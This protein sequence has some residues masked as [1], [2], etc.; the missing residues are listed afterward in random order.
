M[1]V[2]LKRGAGRGVVARVGNL[3]AGR[4]LDTV[5]L[6]SQGR[7]CFV[8]PGSASSSVDLGFLQDVPGVDRVVGVGAGHP[9][10]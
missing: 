5:R 10:G 3:I 7:A 4:G 8:L 1:I 9:R 6:V 2:F